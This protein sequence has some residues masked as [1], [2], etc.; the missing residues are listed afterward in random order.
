MEKDKEDFTKCKYCDKILNFHTMFNTPTDTE[1]NYLLQGKNG[2]RLRESIEQVRKENYSIP[3]IISILQ[4][5]ENIY[6][7]IAYFMEQLPQGSSSTK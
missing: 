4:E 2:E 5:Q 7:A 1:T 6:Q 3:K